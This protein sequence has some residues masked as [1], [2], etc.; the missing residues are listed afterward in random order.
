MATGSASISAAQAKT[1]HNGSV[2]VSRVED[3]KDGQQVDEPQGAE[4]L[5]E[6][7]QIIAQRCLPATLHGDARSLEGELNGEP[8]KIE[9]GEVHDLSIDVAAPRTIDHEGQKQAGDEK[10][11]RHAEWPRES[12]D[13]MHPAIVPGAK[14]DA[15]R[16]VDHHHHDDA[17]AFAGIDPI[18]APGLVGIGNITQIGNPRLKRTTD[19]PYAL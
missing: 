6:S 15:E 19:R 2:F 16:G 7:G 1:N 5:H 3:K 4:G 9:I 12:D 13:I 17:E 8:E 11:I 10:E 14:L 18:D